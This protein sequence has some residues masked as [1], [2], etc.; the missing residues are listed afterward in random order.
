[1]DAFQHV[2]NTVYFRYFERARFAYF[3][4][5]GLMKELKKTGIG[6]ILA[7]SQCRFRTPLTHPDRIRIGTCITDLKPDRFLMKYAVYSLKEKCIAAEGDG[8]II[9]FDYNNNQKTEIPA[10]LFRTLQESM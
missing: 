2:N 7:S 6:P 4:E 9:Y 5:L 1:M 8:F 3:D 10:K